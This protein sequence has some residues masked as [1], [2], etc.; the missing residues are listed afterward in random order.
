MYYYILDE[1]YIYMLGSVTNLLMPR[2][3]CG[4]IH[5]SYSTQPPS[6]VHH[7]LKTCLKHCTIADLLLPS[8]YL[9]ST[10][11]ITCTDYQCMPSAFLPHCLGL[12][13][14]HARKTVPKSEFYQVIRH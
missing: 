10:F 4:L 8:P 14:N 13:S 3:E 1:S 2:Y 12:S 11:I 6:Y 9:F 7:E 5:N